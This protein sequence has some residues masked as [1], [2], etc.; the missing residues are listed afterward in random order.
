MDRCFSGHPL[1]VLSLTRLESAQDK[2]LLVVL[3]STEALTI[4]ICKSHLVKLRQQSFLLCMS[5][6]R[7]YSVYKF[8]YC[9]IYLVRDR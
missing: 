3:I 8:M 6:S 1:Y 5:S 7:H 2:N 9:G 4:M